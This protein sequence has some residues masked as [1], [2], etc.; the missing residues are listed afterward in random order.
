MGLDVYT[1]T[2]SR[3]V[4]RD[5]K[6]VV[7]QFA[8]DTGQP[9]TFAIRDDATGEVQYV[10]PEELV[11]T[12]DEKTR[13]R[14]DIE[15]WRDAIIEQLGQAENGLGT[16]SEDWDK[17]YFTAKPDWSGIGAFLVH[18]AEIVYGESYDRGRDGTVDYFDNSLVQRLIEDED[19]YWTIPRG[20]TMWLP[21]NGRVIFQAPFLGENTNIGSTVVLR[22]ELQEINNRSWRANDAEFAQWFSHFAEDPRTSSSEE[23]HLTTEQRAQ[24]CFA[25]LWRACDFADEHTVPIL[26]DY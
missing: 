20:V 16:W 22:E 17:P 2:L 6:T 15:G 19:V 18:L 12:D 7:Q 23:S 5:W 3:Y 21:L 26:F 11:A 4:S 1:G 14:R 9:L 10:S 8:A 25:V 24:H 13:N